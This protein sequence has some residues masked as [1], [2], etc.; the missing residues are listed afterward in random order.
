MLFFFFFLNQHLYSATA[1]LNMSK[2]RWGEPVGQKK[3]GSVGEWKRSGLGGMG[4][5]THVR[6]GGEPGVGLRKKGGEGREGPWEVGSAGRHS[7]YLEVS[8]AW[9]EEQ[10]GP[11]GGAPFW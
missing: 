5:D 6:V 7:I 2:T 9:A 11:G 3:N 1:T 8:S 4:G 10:G